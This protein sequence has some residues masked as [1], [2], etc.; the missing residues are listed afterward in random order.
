[1]GYCACFTILLAPFSFLPFCGGVSRKSRNQL[2]GNTKV[3]KDLKYSRGYNPG[4]FAG[5][6]G[7]GFFSDTS[8]I[9]LYVVQEL[10]SPAFRGGSSGGVWVETVIGIDSGEGFDLPSGRCPPNHLGLPEPSYDAVGPANKL[11]PLG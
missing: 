8:Y 1:M 7:C 6:G 3:R 10:Y 4:T 11:L 2:K 5:S 9:Q